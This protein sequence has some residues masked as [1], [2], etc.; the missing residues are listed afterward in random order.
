M[1]KPVFD[2]TKTSA[3]ASATFGLSGFFFG[4]KEDEE[5]IFLLIELLPLHKTGRIIKIAA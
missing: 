5:V 3:A 1:E 2:P 4:K